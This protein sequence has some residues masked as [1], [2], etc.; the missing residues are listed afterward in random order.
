MKCGLPPPLRW[1]MARHLWRYLGDWLMAVTPTACL[2]DS[3]RGE[4]GGARRKFGQGA[5]RGGA[6]GCQLELRAEGGAAGGGSGG[7]P[8]VAAALPSA[9]SRAH[10]CKLLQHA[11]QVVI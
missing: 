8:A 10:P 4:Q 9:F 3:C 6:G 2:S 5:G 1:G 11:L 7:L